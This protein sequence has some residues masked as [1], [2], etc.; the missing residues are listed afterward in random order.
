MRNLLIFIAAFLF[1]VQLAAQDNNTDNIALGKKYTMSPPPS[2]RL[3]TDPED[4]VQL[5]D[6]KTTKDY[7]WTQKGTV[8]WQNVPYALVQIDLEK[9][10][11][12][13]RIEMTTA[14]GVAGVTWP[15]A[16][17]VQTS[18]DGKT[19]RNAGDL[20]SLDFK[21]NGPLPEGYAIRCLATDE[22]RSRGR[23]VRFIMMSSGPFIFTDEIRIFRGDDS[24]LALAPTDKK[25]GEV[26]SATPKEFIET[27]RFSIAI[28]RRYT[29]DI[30]E[31]RQVLADAKIAGET[32]K[33]LAERIQSLEKEINNAITSQAPPFAQISEG[34]K[35]IFPLGTLH[36]EIFN[37]HAA[38]WKAAGL[39]VHAVPVSP[40]DKTTLLEIPSKEFLNSQQMIEV[41][42][43]NGEYRAAAFNLYNATDKP[44]SVSIKIDG[45]PATEFAVH[46]VP[47]TDTTQFEPVLAALPFA[48][49]KNDVFSVSVLPGLV[50]QVYLTF[51]P[52]NLPP[53][54]YESN[55]VLDF[56]GGISKRIP[57]KLT[58]WNM[59]F[60]EKTSLL[61]G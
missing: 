55:I 59:K 9:I 58:V 43:M 52:M 44:I 60:P 27:K 31:L 34:F 16:V 19:F 45:I 56:A 47:W 38:I 57:L 5:T 2:Y 30:A 17:F 23:F 8:G 15:T 25:L 12:I 11:P 3:C 24:L 33:N 41:H 42:A 28:Q 61:V 53:K 26:V 4:A 35:T 36:Q 51:R 14:A 54:L 10:E 32:H 22:I 18:D 48:A 7:F 29:T 49:Q 50:K 40:W 39:S 46:D 37:I 1:C 21:A 6:G 13:G 20:M